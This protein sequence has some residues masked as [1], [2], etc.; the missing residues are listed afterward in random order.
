[1]A[2]EMGA[3]ARGRK[4]GAVQSSRHDRRAALTLGAST[5]GG[6]RPEK[7][8]TRCA[9]WSPCTHIGDER[10]ANRMGQR[11]S[12]LTC[13]FAADEQCSCFPIQIIQGQSDYCTGPQAEPGQQEQDRVIALPLC[14]L[15]VTAVQQILDVRGFIIN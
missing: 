6:S 5:V 10:L 11:E 14:R 13:A 3:L 12:I 8:L 15:A 4:P 2:Q 9:W 7:D 1:M